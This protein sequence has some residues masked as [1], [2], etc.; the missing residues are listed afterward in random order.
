MGLL[1]VLYSLT[2]SALDFSLVSGLLIGLPILVIDAT[3]YTGIILE[4]ISEFM[5]CVV[6]PKR[7]LL[8]A[9]KKL[10]INEHISTITKFAVPS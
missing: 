7:T 1:W 5:N 2:Y 8:F 9:G 3:V 10:T 6:A 4:L